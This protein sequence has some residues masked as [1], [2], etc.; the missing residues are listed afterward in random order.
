MSGEPHT[1]AFALPA[2]KSLGEL[3]GASLTIV[4]DSRE[5]DP[6]KF[7][8]FRVIR[9]ALV[10]GDYAIYRCERAATIEKKSVSDL[11]G[12]ISFERERFEREMMRM[13]G[14]PF[15]RL[16]ILGSKS[17]IEQHSYRSK[18]SP[19]A[20]LHSLAAFEVRY[21]CPVCWFQSAEAAALQVES[22]FWWISR[23]IVEDANDLLR[24][25]RLSPVRTGTTGV[26]FHNAT[27][28][29]T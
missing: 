4:Q 29:N 23:Q 24:G 11:V 21:D 3:S 14:Y 17:E 10:T 15:R 9:S 27:K 25:C 26:N 16:V 28:Q 8:H 1:P 19:K 12:S 13:K 6:L 22:W 7:K 5:K 18:M 20:I 2:L